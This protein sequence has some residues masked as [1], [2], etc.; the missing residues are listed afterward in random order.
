MKFTKL[1]TF[2]TTV[3]IGLCSLTGCKTY[4]KESDIYFHKVADYI[5]EVN[6]TKDL[7]YD[8]ANEYFQTTDNIKIIGNSS[9]HNGSFFGT[10]TNAYYSDDVEV[11]VHSA[12]VGSSHAA[13]GVITSNDAITKSLIDSDKYKSYLQLMPFFINDGMNDSGVVATMGCVPVYDLESYKNANNDLKTTPS[14][15]LEKTIYGDMLIRFILDNF[16]S[17]K[18]AAEYITNHVSIITKKNLYNAGY[19]YHYMIADKTS[20]YILEIMGDSFNFITTDSIHAQ[21]IMTDFY[22]SLKEVKLNESKQVTL[23][24]DG[25]PNE[26]GIT[27]HGK[28]LERYNFGV[29]NYDITNTFLGMISVMKDLQYTKCYDTSGRIENFWF[30]EYANGDLTNSETTE[31]YYEDI[32]EAQLKYATKKRSDGANGSIISNTITVYDLDAKEVYVVVEEQANGN[33][34]V[35]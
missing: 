22:L 29:K 27:P 13:V 16:G 1:K 7:N 31:S 5:Y 33:R 3:L 25:K 4:E 12:A 26:S 10:N 28:G 8:K 18:D 30:S 14:G 34:F 24:R 35:M 21:P 20:T 6:F 15:S 2:L 23:N 11:V 19:C 9:I 17:A 32:E